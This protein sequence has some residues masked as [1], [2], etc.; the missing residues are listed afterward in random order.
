MHV[1]ILCS[2]FDAL[3][4]FKIAVATLLRYFSRDFFIKN[5]FGVLMIIELNDCREMLINAC[6]K[7]HSQIF[8]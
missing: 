4:R 2:V 6:D 7:Y 5:K 8:V 1:V 3:C